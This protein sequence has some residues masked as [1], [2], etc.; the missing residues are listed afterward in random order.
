MAEAAQ[1][2]MLVVRVE[3]GVAKKKCTPANFSMNKDEPDELNPSDESPSYPNS[4]ERRH[5]T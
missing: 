1:K 4:H 2:G 3:S 5:C